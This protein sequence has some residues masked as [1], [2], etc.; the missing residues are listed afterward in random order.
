MQAFVSRLAK[1]TMDLNGTEQLVPDMGVVLA[2]RCFLDNGVGIEG[3][4]STDRSSSL[5]A[6]NKKA[7]CFITFG[8][9]AVGQSLPVFD[10]I[11]WIAQSY[12]IT[13]YNATNIFNPGQSSGG[14][15]IILKGV[16]WSNESDDWS[17]QIRAATAGELFVATNFRVIPGPNPQ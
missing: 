3:G 2:A 1:I 6:G 7:S 12:N 17:N 4:M 8:I 10:D 14:N 13:L 15:T 5:V 11:D 16:A 9:P